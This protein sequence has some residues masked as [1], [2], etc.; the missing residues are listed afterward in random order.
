MQCCALA[1]SSVMITTLMPRPQMDMPHLRID[2]TKEGVTI[3]Q[4]QMPF[5]PI[6]IVQSWTLLLISS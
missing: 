1:I 5:Y 2:P 3:V 4:I 6:A